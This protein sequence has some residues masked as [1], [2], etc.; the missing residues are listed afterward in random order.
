MT[1]YNDKDMNQDIVKNI[2]SVQ[3]RIV[4]ACAASG[5]NPDEVKLLLA[6]KTVPVA[7]IKVAL[8]AGY[9]LIAENKIQ[10]LKEKFEGLKE[11]LHV[12]HFIGHLQS[13]KIKE[14]LKYDVTCIQS[15]DRYDLAEKLHHR[16]LLEGRQ[17][18]VLIQVNT[19]YEESKYGVSPNDVLALVE[20]VS[21]LN[22]IRIKGLMTIGMLSNKA[23]KVRKCFR[24]LKEIQQKIISNNFD[25]VNM[26]ELSMGMSGDMEIAIEEGA[27]MIRIGTAIFGH[28]PTPDSFYWD[29]NNRV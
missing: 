16:L 22:T 4:K 1:W 21:K 11:L 6:T 24:L 26:H 7:R 25:H 28:R 10:E 15:L 17:M 20:K 18:E 29:E 14:V 13:N 27:T 12:N 3:R 19:S 5:R 23:E 9:T 8:E 2:D